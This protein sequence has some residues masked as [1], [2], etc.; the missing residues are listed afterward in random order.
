MKKRHVLITAILIGLGVFILFVSV[1]LKNI[2]PTVIVERGATG[3]LDIRLISKPTNGIWELKDDRQDIFV[4]KT[5]DMFDIKM[6]LIL[7]NGSM[8]EIN[9]RVKA[10]PGEKI[11]LGG[12]ENWK[13]YLDV[14]EI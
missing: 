13:I 12:T 11:M 14:P 5:D 7:D 2:K 8:R 3:D 4:Q 1:V 9:T 10:G 6:K